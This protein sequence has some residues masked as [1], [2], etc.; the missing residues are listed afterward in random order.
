MSPTAWRWARLLGGAAILAALVWRLGAGPFVAG[1]RGVDA[2]A[3]LAALVLTLGTTLASA[4]RWRLVAHGLGVPLTLRT[5][6]ASYYRSQFLN[7]VLPGGVLGDVHRGVRH[8]R[9]VGDTPRGLRAVAWERSAGQ[10]VQVV[11]VGLVLTVVPSPVRSWLPA[12]VL[13]AGALVAG[14]V[15]RNHGRPSSGALTGPGWWARS[16]RAV[17][18]DLRGGVLARE[19]LPGVV[20]ASTVAVAGHT[21]AFL[22]AARAAG[23]Q[24]SWPTLLPLALLVM[25]AMAV[26]ANVAGWG[27]RE[28]VAAWAFAAAG[29]GADAGVATAVVYGVMV[30]VAALPGAG[31]LLAEWLADSRVHTSGAPAAAGRADLVDGGLHG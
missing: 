16:R 5:A 26:P 2:G 8:G 28:G 14:A 4:W 18:A 24:A 9:A 6:V 23:V 30:L 20:V 13:A 12:V 10:V 29:L 27:P 19:V 21:L 7:T 1:L 15:L 3:L 22:V 25:L 11:L 31:V 17:A